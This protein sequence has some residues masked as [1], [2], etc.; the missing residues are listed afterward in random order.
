MSFYR[1]IYFVDADFIEKRAPYRQDHFTF[2][3]PYFE[4]GELIMGGAFD[5]L[6]EGVHIIF[7]ADDRKVVEDF[8]INDPYVKSGIVIDWKVSQWNVAIGPQS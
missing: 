5:D 2:L 6:S 4:R 3:T 8:A 1:L 7:R